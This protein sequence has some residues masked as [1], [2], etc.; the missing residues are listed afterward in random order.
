VLITRVMSDA[1]T[2]ISAANIRAELLRI[3]EDQKAGRSRSGAPR[4]WWGLVAVLVAAA[5]T[6]AI[7]YKLFF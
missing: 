3:Q 7:A 2:P 5:T 4:L 1:D 6:G